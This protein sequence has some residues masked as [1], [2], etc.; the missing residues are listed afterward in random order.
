MKKLLYFVLSFFALAWMTVSCSKDQSNVAPRPGTPNAANASKYDYIGVQHNDGMDYFLKV[1]DFKD[2]RNQVEPV[3][4]SFLEGQG[5]NRKEAEAILHD[6]SVDKVIHSS[7]PADA[8][9]AYYKEKG[10][11]QELNYLEKIK[12][13]LSP[14]SATASVAVERL[15][16]IER[17]VETDATLSEASQNSLLQGLAI[18]KH[19]AQYWY[20]HAQ[21]GEKS[22]WIIKGNQSGSAARRIN[23]WVVGLMDL[24]GGIMGGLPGGIASSLISVADQLK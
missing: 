12:V 10:M 16:E 9:G 3:T 18:G 19:S 11:I 15:T 14:E 21:L 24:A 8:L 23:W 6:P 2:Y 5:Y 4:L 1:A 13:A 17:A 20:G 7:S 22:P